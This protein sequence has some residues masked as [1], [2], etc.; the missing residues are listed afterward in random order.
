LLDR[1]RIALEG[2]FV[3]TFVLVAPVL[4]P[5]SPLAGIPSR[6]VELTRESSAEPRRAIGHVRGTMNELEANLTVGARDAVEDSVAAASNLARR[7]TSA[8]T[9]I[10]L[11][12]G[13]FQDSAASGQKD[14]GPNTNDRKPSV[15]QE[16]QD[17]RD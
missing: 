16:K 3:A 12:L 8:W 7:S 13:T 5:G 15:V 1:P 9:T 2:A 4:A 14:D 11:R 17:E 6:A 10:R